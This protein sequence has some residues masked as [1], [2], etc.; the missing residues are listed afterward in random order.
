[1]NHTNE[2]DTRW[3]VQLAWVQRWPDFCRKCRARGSIYNPGVYR[4]A[5]G[6]GDPP[7]DELCHEC[8]GKSRHLDVAWGHC[9]RCGKYGI[10]VADLGVTDAIECPSRGWAN[11]A[12]ADDHL[13]EMDCTCEEDLTWT[14]EWPTEP[15]FY[16][17]YGWPYR[18][19]EREPEWCFV[20]VSQ[21]ANKK[22]MYAT[23][24]HVMYKSDGGTGKWLPVVLPEAPEVT[25]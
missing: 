20:R 15:G 6:S 9:P 7:S 14:T 12:G 22:P 13:P 8:L 10:Y 19:R 16:W 24:G 5:D 11:G 21:I 2:C 4:Y 23:N 25:P 3:N 18:D 17:F 1:M